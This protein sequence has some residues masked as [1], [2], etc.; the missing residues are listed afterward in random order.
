MIAFNQPDCSPRLGFGLL[1]AGVASGVLLLVEGAGR[2]MAA[3]LVGPDVSHFDKLLHAAA[4]AWLATLF[5]LGSYLLGWPRARLPRAATCATLT[6]TLTMLLGTAVE[7]VQAHVGALHGRVFDFRDIA[8]DALGSGLAILFW[9]VVVW[10]V[11]RLY[12]GRKSGP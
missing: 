6:F 4:H 5:F 10:R 1:L 8:A 7:M 3:V 9:L 12:T 11:P 2:P